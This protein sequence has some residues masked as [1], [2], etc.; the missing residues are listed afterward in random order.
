MMSNGL[1]V[2]SLK[3]A[4][5]TKFGS[6]TS[7]IAAKTSGENIMVIWL[8]WQDGDSYKTEATKEGKGQ[9]PK[10]ISAASV[11]SDYR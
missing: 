6:I 8:D 4:D 11:N 3:I 7:T 1:P 5:Q 2:V 10:Y 9:E